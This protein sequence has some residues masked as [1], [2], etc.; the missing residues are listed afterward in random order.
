MLDPQAFRLDG[1]TV[2]VTGA[3]RGLGR[4]M[5]IGFAVYGADIVMCDRLAEDLADTKETIDVQGTFCTEDPETVSYPV[6]IW[7][8]LDNTGSMN[9]NDPGEERFNAADALSIALE[10]TEPPPSM[11]FGAMIFSEGGLGTQRITIPDRFTP[12]ASTF[13]ANVAAV[14]GNA[15][16][17]TPYVT[18]LNFSFGELNQDIKG[19]G[20]PMLVRVYELRSEVAFQDAEFFALQTTDKAVLG[21]D[22]LAVDQ[23]IIRPGETRQIL[24][25]SHPQTTAIGVFAAYRDLPN[26]TWRVVHTLAPAAEKIWYGVVLPIHQ[27][28]LKIAL[29]AKAIVLTD[30]GVGQDPARYANESMKGLDSTKTPLDGAPQKAGELLQSVPKTADVPTLDGLKGLI[31]P[32]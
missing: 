14:R 9:T 3:A 28:K 11:F 13:V 19:R 30:E 32:Q 20:A 15:N 12:V 25:K 2:L 18:A 16:G 21:V 1:K 4:A 10:D 26:A 29:Q 5:A 27:T 6:K 31:K 24:R 23:Y 17:G 8:V 22:L 7:M